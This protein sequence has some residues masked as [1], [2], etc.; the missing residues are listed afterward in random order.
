MLFPNVLYTKNV[1]FQR[2]LP[3]VRTK[4]NSLHGNRNSGVT[5]LSILLLEMVVPK[6]AEMECM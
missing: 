4:V 5:D 2:K 6:I 3:I 1:T